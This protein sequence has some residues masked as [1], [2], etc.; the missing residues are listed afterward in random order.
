M[1]EKKKNSFKMTNENA[2]QEKKE[3][4]SNH[5]L[6]YEELALVREQIWGDMED[7]DNEWYSDN[8]EA[9]EGRRKEEQKLK[10]RKVQRK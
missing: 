10:K 9:K 5:R 2:E 7:Q 3:K 1:T 6:V 8:F 4:N